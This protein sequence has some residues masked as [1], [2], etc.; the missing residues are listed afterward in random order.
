MHKH[1]W[2]TDD[3]ER[4]GYHFICKDCGE[5]LDEG[6][7][8]IARCINATS[9]LSAEDARASVEA[10]NELAEAA[11]EVGLLDVRYVVKDDDPLLQYARALSDECPVC[12]SI[13]CV[14]DARSDDCVWPT[15]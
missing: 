3:Y 6:P 12:K 7:D 11:R 1:E 15:R 8:W 13:H 14:C 5:L 2:I 10:T 9:C 4:E